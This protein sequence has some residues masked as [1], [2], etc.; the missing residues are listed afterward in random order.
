MG[1]ACAVLIGAGASLV[2]LPVP[3]QA[4]PSLARPPEKS[5]LS[6]ACIAAGRKLTR[7]QESL[8]TAKSDL[9]RYTKARASCATKSACARD[10]DRI[11]ALNKR[12][13]RYETRLRTFRNN[14]VESCKTG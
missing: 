14:Q 2:A 7:E 8:D 5:S 13:P 4:P 3:G 6:K 1:V 9:D 12:I 11:A 10:D